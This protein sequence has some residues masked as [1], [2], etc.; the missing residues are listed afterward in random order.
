MEQVKLFSGMAK[1]FSP[2]TTGDTVDQLS[3]NILYLDG[4]FTNENLDNL[5]QLVRITVENADIRYGFV[6]TT[7]EGEE[8]SQGSNIGHVKSEGD[9]IWLES[10]EQA[11]GFRF[12]NKVDSTNAKLQITAYYI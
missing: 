1:S 9:E 8:P 6:T 4:D 10:F 2:V 11:K 3:N 12:I 5:V 7:G